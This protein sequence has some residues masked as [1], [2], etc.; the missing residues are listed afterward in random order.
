MSFD[1]RRDESIFDTFNETK[2]LLFM[3]K[4]FYTNKKNK[5]EFQSNNSFQRYIYLIKNFQ[6]KKYIY[7]LIFVII[8]FIISLITFNIISK[9]IRRY[10]NKS[11]INTKYLAQNYIKLSANND[12]S[13]N[14]NLLFYFIFS[15]SKIIIIFYLK[16]NL[17][18]M[19]NN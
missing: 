14:N 9:S 19:A 11:L 8:I 15:S 1:S 3:R 2:R 13:I 18:F 6:M 7:Y 5:K 10:E 17:S 12:P 4:Q 16:D